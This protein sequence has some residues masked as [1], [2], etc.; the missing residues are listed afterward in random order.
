MN[1]DDPEMDKLINKYKDSVDENDFGF[2]KADKR[3]FFA[4]IFVIYEIH[5][6][7]GVPLWIYICRLPS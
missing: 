2:Y 3:R 5:I 6:E 1:L 7:R 4:E